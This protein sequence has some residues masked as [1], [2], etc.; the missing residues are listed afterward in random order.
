MF[1][2]K[3]YKKKFPWTA[4]PNPS[5]LMKIEYEIQ[6]IFALK[7][8]VWL[9]ECNGNSACQRNQDRG[10]KQQTAPSLYVKLRWKSIYLCVLS[11]RVGFLQDLEPALYPLCDRNCKAKK[12]NCEKNC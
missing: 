8:Y 5:E 10:A 12:Q 7:I 3:K 11:E 4:E 1:A 6:D 9:C 2:P